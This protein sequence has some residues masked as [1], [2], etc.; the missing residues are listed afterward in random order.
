[1]GYFLN[2]FILKNENDAIKFR[3]KFFTY[4][5]LFSLGL[6]LITFLIKDLMVSLYG[7]QFNE[8]KNLFF[9][10]IIS[11]IPQ[12]INAIYQ[13]NFIADSRTL[14]LFKITFFNSLFLIVGV[15]L[16]Y[17]FD[18]S[19]LLYFIILRLINFISISISFKILS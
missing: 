10:F 11:I 14:T 7:S 1:M 15:L 16:L 6:A 18:V 4:S 12:I 2:Q 5:I 3:R 8:L 13:Q 9:L 19:V 17:Y